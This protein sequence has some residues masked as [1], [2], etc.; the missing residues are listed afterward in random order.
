MAMAIGN[1]LTTSSA[2]GGLAVLLVRDNVTMFDSR[3]PSYPQSLIDADV[4]FD[5][6]P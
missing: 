3:S 1:P 4:D 2:C 5:V 6:L